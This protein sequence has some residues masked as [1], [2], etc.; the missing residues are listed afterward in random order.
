MNTILIEVPYNHLLQLPSTIDGKAALDLITNATTVHKE[1]SYSSGKNTYTEGDTG[2]TVSIINVS[3]IQNK[4]EPATINIES[5][6]EENNRLTRELADA[7]EKLA[8]K[9]PSME[10]SIL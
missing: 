1:Y 3:D 5:I 10:V 2:I 9:K 8:A 6:M 4:A 7:L